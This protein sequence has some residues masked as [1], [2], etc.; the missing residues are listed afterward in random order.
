VD[1]INKKLAGAQDLLKKSVLSAAELDKVKSLVGGAGNLLDAMGQPDDDLEK[2]I[3]GRV[4]D[5][6][7]KFTRAFQQKQVCRDIRGQVAIPFGMLAANPAGSQAE[8]DMN[9]RKLAVIGALVDLGQADAEILG[10]LERPDLGSLQMAEQLLAERQDGITLE[11]LS[12]EITQDPPQLRFVIDRDKVR[13][14]TP[15]MIKL[16]FNRQLYNRAAA[17]RRIECKWDFDHEGLTEKGWE[18]YHYF[19]KA[20]DYRVTVTFRDV[21]Q[22]PIEAGAAVEKTVTVDAQQAEASNWGDWTGGWGKGED[23]VAGHD[24]CCVCGVSAGIW[25]RYGEEP[26]GAEGHEAGG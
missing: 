1:E 10:Y 13:T 14:N 21:D 11:A 8:R 6:K 25:D 22:N 12:A 15:L 17:R 3:G 18:V 20:R 23:C 24:E 2:T 9:S 5:L 7:T 19:P 26:A 4:K 16:M